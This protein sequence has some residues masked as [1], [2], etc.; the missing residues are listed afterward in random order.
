VI[1]VHGN[2]NI[3][4]LCEEIG[5]DIYKSG[6]I[7]RY[8]EHQSADSNAQIMLMCVPSVFNWDGVEGE[9]LWHFTKIEKSLWKKGKLPMEYVGVPLPKIRVS[10]QQNKQGKGKNKVEKILCLNNL[11][12]FQKNGCLVCMVQVAEHD[13]KR[14]SVL[15]E[16]FNKMGLCHWALRQKS[17]MIMNYNG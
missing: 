1:R 16:K 11:V 9:I 7:M 17:L 2:D 6:L 8:K 13:W 10:W 15:R 14:L 4:D 5:W 12:G 3:K